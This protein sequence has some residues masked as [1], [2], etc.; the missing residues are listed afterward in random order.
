[1]AHIDLFE[2]FDEEDRHQLACAMVERFFAK[3]EIIVREGDEGSS[4]FVLAE[5]ALDVALRHA[6]GKDRIVDRMVPGDVFG[7]MSLLTGQP[8]SATVIA[9]IDTVVYEI[10]KDDLVPVLQRRPEIATALAVLMADRQRQNIDRNR[11]LEQDAAEAALPSK[12]DLLTRIRTLFRL[13]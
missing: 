8:R 12:D 1:M 4:L 6:S 11:A 13:H 3:G 5:G 9:A 7:E 10:G 2:V